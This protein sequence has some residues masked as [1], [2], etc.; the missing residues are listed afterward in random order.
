MIAIPIPRHSHCHISEVE[1][2][3]AYFFGTPKP[4]PGTQLIAVDG[5][6]SGP[7]VSEN[8]GHLKCLSPEESH[9][10]KLSLL[11]FFFQMHIEAKLSVNSTGCLQNHIP[12][13]HFFSEC[14]LRHAQIF[15]ICRDIHAN[16]PMNGWRQ[17]YFLGH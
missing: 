6:S 2:L 12:S 14:R 8:R 17:A 5:P 13:G 3:T 9:Q 16:K 1:Y 4:L 10:L 11:H 7:D 15:A